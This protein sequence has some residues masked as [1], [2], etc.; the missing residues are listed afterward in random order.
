MSRSATADGAASLTV[1]RLTPGIWRPSLSGSGFPFAIMRQLL[2]SPWRGLIPFD[3]R[4][5]KAHLLWIVKLERGQFAELKLDVERAAAAV[6][7][8]RDKLLIDLT[9][10]VTICRTVA[11][12]EMD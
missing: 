8:W 1:G 9:T 12:G 11:A 3:S 10:T 4:L 6:V 7:A 5:V 2:R